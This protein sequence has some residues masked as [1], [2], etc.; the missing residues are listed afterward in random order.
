MPIYEYE[1]NKCG[2]KYELVLMSI[3]QKAE[4]ECPKCKCRDARKLVSRVRYASGPA[5]EGLASNAEARLLKSLGGK[6]D[7]Q[8]RSQIKQLAKTAAKR[9]KKRFD[10]MMDTGKSDTVDY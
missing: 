3:S 2:K 10:S 9:G 5:E 8:T 6:V 1:C 7:D 4:P